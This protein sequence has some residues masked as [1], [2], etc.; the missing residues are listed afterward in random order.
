MGFTTCCDLPAALPS[1]L[2]CR[3]CC[4]LGL[5]SLA[6]L[7]VLR[8]LKALHLDYDNLPL[9]QDCSVFPP[10]VQPTKLLAAQHPGHA[11]LVLVGWC[12]DTAAVESCAARSPEA[13]RLP[14]W[15]M[16]QGWRSC[17]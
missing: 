10:G 3:C 9:V 4:R 17:L 13:G 16:L 5:T 6:W 15:C 11:R 12:E 8:H 1:P 14:A 7:A 2:G